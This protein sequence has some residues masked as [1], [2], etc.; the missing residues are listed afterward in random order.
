MKM[1][2]DER[3]QGQV[4]KYG[5]EAF[6]ISCGLFVVMQIISFLGYKMEWSYQFC[7]VLPMIY[8]M[9]RC[10]IGGIMWIN[11]KVSAGIGE[12][13]IV[14]ILELLISLIFGAITVYKNMIIPRGIVL[15]SLSTIG[16]YLFFTV[17]VGIVY[18]VMILTV[19][20][21]LYAVSEIQNRRN[22]DRDK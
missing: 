22:F 15:N 4:Q 16:N 18:A 20:A 11:F 5:Y 17:I 13:I 14:F 3:I 21:V 2:K 7:T 19:T 9:T 12:I 1:I 8:F 6:S 10:A